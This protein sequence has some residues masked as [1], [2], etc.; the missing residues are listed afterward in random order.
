ML[1]SIVS[2]L[3][4]KILFA[5]DSAGALVTALLLGIVLVQ[6]E[7]LF[8]MPSIVLYGLAFLAAGYS[9]YSLLCSV[10]LGEYTSPFLYGIAV[11]N[12][13]YCFLTLS[14]VVLY[15]SELSLYG[16]VYF[17]GEAGIILTMATVEFKMASR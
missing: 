7:S 4:P 1:N 9:V 17:V 10:L 2:M 14:L 13:L 6:F 11:A 12:Y 15:F 5:I 16:I 8:G 3:N